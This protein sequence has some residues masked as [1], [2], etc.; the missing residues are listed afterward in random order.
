MI[1][2]MHDMQAAMTPACSRRGRGA[3][4]AYVANAAGRANAI[5]GGA[6]GGF[7]ALAPKTT[8][9]HHS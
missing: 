8:K 1:H 4:L 2:S 6:T 3:E 5:F 9:H 7:W